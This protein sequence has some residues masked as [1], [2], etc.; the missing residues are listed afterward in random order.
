MSFERVYRLRRHLEG[1][2]GEHEGRTV[3]CRPSS[4]DPRDYQYLKVAAFGDQEIKRIDYRN[5]LPVVFDQ[6]QRG[7]CV[8]CASAWTVKAWQEMRS[9][10]YPPGGLSA[11]FIY[12][13]CKE[14]DGAPDEEGTQPRVAMKVMQKSGVCPEKVMPYAALTDLPA[15]EV[16]NVPDEAWGAAEPFRIGSY[17]QLCAAGDIKRD[18]TLSA[19][20]K[21]LQNE[22]PFLMALLV[23]DNFRPDRDNR[24]PLP[25]GPVRGGHAVGIA[26]DIPEEGCLILRNSWGSSWG[27][28]GYAYLPYDWLTSQGEYGWD[29]FEAWT[30]TDAVS[31]RSADRI[32]VTPGANYMT[33][34][35]SRVSLAHPV[36]SRNDTLMMSVY[37]LAE[38]MGYQVTVAGKK[39]ILT[40]LG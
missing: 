24:L 38:N 6:G 26:G 31:S 25:Q 15:P 10:D 37:D 1:L 35:G 8:A 19:M 34:D 40:R 7:S 22:G 28:N 13:L 3:H 16:P 17:A 39:L 9:G 36:G 5:Q 33:V 32:V 20:R 23:C 2:T 11:A 27:D 29:I 12:T 21:A 30:A 14:K 4:F 18:Q